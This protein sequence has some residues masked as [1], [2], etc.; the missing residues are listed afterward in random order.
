MGTCKALGST[1]QRIF[2][3]GCLVV[4]AGCAGY[5]SESPNAF[6][7]KIQAAGYSEEQGPGPLIKVTYK[8]SMVGGATMHMTQV[9]ALYRCAEIAQREGKPYF[10]LY[11]D[12]P[13]AL[14]DRPSDTNTVTLVLGMP[15]SHA[16][17]MLHDKNGP[18]LLST[19][20]VLARLGPKV[21][22]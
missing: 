11:H 22:K 20:E 17:I 18:G 4:L 16:Y 6:P 19:A 14:A 1:V 7:W 12:L 9:Y 5:R 2:V 21:G 3:A 8:V 15:S 13:A 10:A